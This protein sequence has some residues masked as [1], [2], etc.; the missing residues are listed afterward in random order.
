MTQNGEMLDTLYGKITD[1]LKKKKL[2]ESERVQY[3]FMEVL[4]IY[5]RADHSKVR[6]MWNTYVPVAWVMGIAAATFIGLLVSGR[7]SVVIK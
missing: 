7:V 1:H 2:A 6:K 4:V 5:L 3:E